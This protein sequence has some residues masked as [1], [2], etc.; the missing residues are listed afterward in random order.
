ML[1]TNRVLC[2][3]KP[4]KKGQIIGSIIGLLIGC[5]IA[6]SVWGFSSPGG[7]VI[8]AGV[9]IGGIFGHSIAKK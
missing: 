3:M 4:E 6:Y 5:T 8:L 1:E 2:N 7:I 9:G